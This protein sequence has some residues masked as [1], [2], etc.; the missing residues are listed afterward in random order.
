LLGLINAAR[1]PL[2]ADP[3]LAR[4]Q[5]NLRTVAKSLAALVI[6]EKRRENLVNVLSTLE[7]EFKSPTGVFT[8]QTLWNQT[9][10]ATISAASTTNDAARS[11]PL[12]APF[13]LLPAGQWFTNKTVTITVKQGQRAP[14]FD[15]AGLADATRAGVTTGETPAGKSTQT[16]AAD[17]SAARSIQF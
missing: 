17:L 14:L 7:E 13:N 15:V 8:L 16:A 2:A 9:A 12:E 10:N 11:L 4:L 5:T 6:A 3:L 1:G